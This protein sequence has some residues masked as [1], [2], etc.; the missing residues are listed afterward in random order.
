MATIQR[1]PESRVDYLQIFVFVGEQNLPAAERLIETFDQKLEL[2]ADMPGLGPA[3]P[4]FGKGIRSFPVGSYIIFYRP[5]DGG[6]ELLR[7]LHGA[8]NLRKIFRKK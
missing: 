2:L 8:R 5:V 7:V 3:R 1:T 6:I 4:E